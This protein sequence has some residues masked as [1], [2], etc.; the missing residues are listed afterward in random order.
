MTEPTKLPESA[1]VA[2][3]D[4]V[5]SL[6]VKAVTDEVFAHVSAESAPGTVYHY[7]TS[8][9]ACGILDT[10]TIW[11]TD[12]RFL[13]RS[14][15]ENRALSGPGLGQSGPHPPVWT[16]RKSRNPVR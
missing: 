10:S 11:A 15:G 7:T 2:E 4:S 9:G 8:S 6:A 12:A 13:P 14:S 1:E 16:A 3:P 5:R